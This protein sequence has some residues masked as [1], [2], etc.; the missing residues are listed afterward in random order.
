MKGYAGKL[1]EIDLTKGESRETDLNKDITRRFIGGR[2]LAAKILWDELGTKW[3]EV[4][5]LGPENILLVLN[6]P[7][8]GFFPGGRICISGKSPQS[9]GIIGSTIG[10][11]FSI[12]L[13][14]AGYDGLIIKGKAYHPSYI[15]V[16]DSKVEI[17]D[18]QH[19]W[20]KDGK[21]TL[22]TLTKETTQLLHKHKDYT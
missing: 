4:D 20:G 18:V 15:F 7:L 3:D 10:G 11:E 6:G 13:K 16:V 21:E 22:K 12:D 1:L 9:N 2:G 17:K 14:C 5:P 8:T 19:I